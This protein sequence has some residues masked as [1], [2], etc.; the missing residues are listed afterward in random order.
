MNPATS[1]ASVISMCRYWA[2]ETINDP[3]M[4]VEEYRDLKFCL[5]RSADLLDTYAKTIALIEKIDSRVV[6][7]LMWLDERGRNSTSYGSHAD[8]YEIAARRLR[9][10]MHGGTPIDAPAQGQPDA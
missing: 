3:L 9:E 8:A 7:H 6:A 5:E 4:T 2:L 10:A 1:V